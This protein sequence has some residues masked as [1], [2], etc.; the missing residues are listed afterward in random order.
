ME[1][2]V[3]TTLHVEGNFDTVCEQRKLLR[4]VGAGTKPPK[5]FGSCDAGEVGSECCD[6]QKQVQGSL[7]HVPTETAVLKFPCRHPRHLKT[8]VHIHTQSDCLVLRHI[9][10]PFKIRPLCTGKIPMVQKCHCPITKSHTHTVAPTDCRS[11]KT[12]VWSRV[13]I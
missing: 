4:V 5:Q 6:T 11:I 3:F 13:H 7:L 8:P 2:P 1:H 12:Y 10:T 9:H